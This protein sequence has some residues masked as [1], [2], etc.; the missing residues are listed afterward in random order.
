MSLK[1]ADCCYC[2]DAVSFGEKFFEA[3]KDKD[4]ELLK[5]YY[6][7][8]GDSCHYKKDVTGIEIKRCKFFQEV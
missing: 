2:G 7:N 3:H 5:R 4:T 1:C 6:C 8:C